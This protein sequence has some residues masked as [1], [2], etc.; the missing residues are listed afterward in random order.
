MPIKTAEVA[1]RR[2]LVFRD[3]DEILREVDRLA[4]G[5]PTLLGNWSLGQIC[6]HLA[7]A[8]NIALDGRRV[9]TPWAF[10]VIGPLVKKRILSQG[11]RP[12]FQLNEKTASALLPGAAT[13][14][15]GVAALR[16]AVERWK[17]EPQRHRHP[18]F[19][20]MTDSEWDRLHLRHA[21]MHLS[22]V[23]PGD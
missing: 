4:A 7:N 3:F 23:L 20:R 18:F 11:M 2:T 21:E 6:Q 8:M 10:Y 13:T 16:T 15:E 17:Q 5:N 22:F 1:N 9:R 19:G 12:G 14:D